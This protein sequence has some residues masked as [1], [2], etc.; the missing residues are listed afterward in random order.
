MDYSPNVLSQK[1]DWATKRRFS[2][3]IPGPYHI[4]DL[5][6]ISSFWRPSENQEAHVSHQHFD[7]NLLRSCF[8]KVLQ[9]IF[10]SRWSACKGCSCHVLGM[11]ARRS[12]A[13]GLLPRYMYPITTMP[14]WLQTILKNNQT[15]NLILQHNGSNNAGRRTAD[16]FAFAIDLRC[17]DNFDI[18]KYTLFSLTTIK[19]TTARKST[20]NGPNMTH[21]R[22]IR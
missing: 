15:H 13:I 22:R 14:S 16:D 21:V 7:M 11:A 18:C 3:S 1:P 8:S 4:A 12:Q 20:Q 2:N 10:K 17:A 9:L 6:H 19:L 5:E